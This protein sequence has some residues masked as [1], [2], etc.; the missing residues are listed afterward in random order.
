[1]AVAANEPYRRVSRDNGVFDGALIGAAVGAGGAGA[2]IFGARM[3]YNG[4]EKKAKRTISDMDTKLDLLVDKES[5]AN[6]KYDK[7]IDKI[8]NRRGFPF[9]ES[10]GRKEKNLD[11]LEDRHQ[12]NL[13][14]IRG[15][16]GD[17]A[18]TY[19]E[20]S[21]P[22]YVSNKQSAHMYSKMGGGWR[23]AGIIGASAVVAGGIGMG[24]DGLKH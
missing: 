7:K 6:G 11:K 22:D 3:S 4:I 18:N 13:G 2:G 15:K 5:N 16:A 19:A 8:I 10:Q 1:M 21:R 17:L 9:R 14:K 23:K 12:K 20:V 24:I